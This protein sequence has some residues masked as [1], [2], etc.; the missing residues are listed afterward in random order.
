MRY[1]EFAL[2]WQAQ[3]CFGIT[4]LVTSCYRGT[5]GKKQLIKA[6]PAPLIRNV[7]LSIYIVPAIT[8]LTSS[9]NYRTLPTVSLGHEFAAGVRNCC[10]IH[11]PEFS[12]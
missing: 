6:E 11:G 3:R 4:S 1:L 7:A 5:A 2:Y 12:L 10:R 9:P 8:D